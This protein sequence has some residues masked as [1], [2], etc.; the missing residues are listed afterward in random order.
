M[1]HSYNDRLFVL[2]PLDPKP[3]FQTSAGEPAKRPR[4]PC[5]H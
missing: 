5:V 1:M 2:T 3:N 4:A